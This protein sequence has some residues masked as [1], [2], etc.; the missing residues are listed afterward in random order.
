MADATRGGA[1]K[2]IRTDE[3]K[4]KFDAG[5]CEELQKA[6][7]RCLEDVGYDR[8]V[9]KTACKPQYDAYKECRQKQ[10]DAKKAANA[11]WVEQFKFWKQR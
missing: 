1:N 8:A 7:M 3:D 4:V 6:S 11:E 2:V 5:S 10:L 9:A